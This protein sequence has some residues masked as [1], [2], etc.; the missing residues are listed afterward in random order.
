MRP[1][2]LTEKSRPDD[3]AKIPLG[4]L[5]TSN[6][7]RCTENVSTAQ[8]SNLKLINRATLVLR[9]CLL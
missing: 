4:K 5:K 3:L 1:S 9:S 7:K 6:Y 8:K 2:I